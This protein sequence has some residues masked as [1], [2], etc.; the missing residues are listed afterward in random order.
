MVVWRGRYWRVG[1]NEV[2]PE[3]VDDEDDRSGVCRREGARFLSACVGFGE[4]KTC[5]KES[6]RVEVYACKVDE[7]DP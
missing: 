4:R 5:K 7:E 3:S 1:R 2:E 6:T